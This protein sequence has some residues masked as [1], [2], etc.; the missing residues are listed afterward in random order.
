MITRTLDE[1]KLPVMDRPDL[2]GEDLGVKEADPLALGGRGI[3][4]A[5]GGIS[6]R[7]LATLVAK[8]GFP[9]VRLGGRNIYPL[10]AVRE[11]IAKRTETS[12]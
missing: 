10:E 8:E 4:A 2:V 7:T 3:C 5:L 6:E 12:R 9:V 1:S 11:W